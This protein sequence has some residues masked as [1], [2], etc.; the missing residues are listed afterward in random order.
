MSGR[1]DSGAFLQQDG[2]LLPGEWGG[3]ESDLLGHSSSPNAWLSALPI[4][5][6]ELPTS[7]A[8]L[9]ASVFASLASLSRT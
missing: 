9:G 7:P 2:L 5:G 3:L 4:E 1:L 6:L 8:R